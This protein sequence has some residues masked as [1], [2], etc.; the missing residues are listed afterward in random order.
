M[1]RFPDFARLAARVKT[2]GLRHTA[3]MWLKRDDGNVYKTGM[4]GLTA[5]VTSHFHKC[6]SHTFLLQD[7][8]VTP[9]VYTRSKYIAGILVL[10]KRVQECGKKLYGDDVASDKMYYVLQPSNSAQK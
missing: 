1:W 3:H 5:R 2:I 8:G 4:P 10:K 6:Y 7:P 9:A